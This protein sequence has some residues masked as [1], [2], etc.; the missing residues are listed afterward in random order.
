MLVGKIVLFSQWEQIYVYL[1]YLSLYLE[2]LISKYTKNTTRQ[3]INLDVWYDIRGKVM[4]SPSVEL[5]IESRLKQ[6]LI[7]YAVCLIGGKIL[8]QREYLKR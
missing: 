7:L 3:V 4:P 8:S 2:F 1:C 6:I 5:L